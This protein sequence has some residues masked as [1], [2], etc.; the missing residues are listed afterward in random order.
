[1]EKLKNI[2]MYVLGALIVSGFFALIYILFLRPAPTENEE[3]LFIAVGAMIGSFNQV[4]GFFYGSSKSSHDKT[5]M[6]K[7]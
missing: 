1:M 5:E 4:V 3:I 7:K 6:L 2:S